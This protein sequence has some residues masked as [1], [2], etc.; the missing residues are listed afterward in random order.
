MSRASWR[1]IALSQATI[2]RAACPLAS[3]LWPNRAGHVEHALKSHVEGVLAGS[4]WPV[5]PDTR[6]PSSEGRTTSG[7]PGGEYPQLAADC[8]GHPVLASMP[9]RRRPASSARRRGARGLTARSGHRLAVRSGPRGHLGNTRQEPRRGRPGR[10]VRSLADQGCHLVLDDRPTLTGAHP[11][12]ST[13]SAPALG[14]SWRGK[15]RGLAADQDRRPGPRTTALP[16]PLP[17]CRPGRHQVAGHPPTLTAQRRRPAWPTS[18]APLPGTLRGRPGRE[19]TAWP[20]TRGHRSVPND[21]PPSL[22]CRRHRLASRR[23][24]RGARGL[25]D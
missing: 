13:S 22:V 24:K 23:P 8:A 1:E 17:G 21:G 14:A 15:P 2:D 12:W 5:T 25:A 9:A 7:H 10:G 19:C 20:P 16:S 4:R 11:I 6:P 3:A 18:S